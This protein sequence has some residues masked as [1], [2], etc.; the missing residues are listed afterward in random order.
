MSNKKNPSVADVMLGL[1]SIPIVH[2]KTF[3]KETLEIMNKFNLGIA[4]IVNNSGMLLGIVT[5]GDLRRKLLKVQKPFS[6]FFIDDILDHAIHNPVTT[7]PESSIE[8][9]V[10]VMGK[11]HVWDL[12]VVNDKGILVGLLHLHPAIKALLGKE[13]S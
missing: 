4:C 8:D 12:P 11:R 7:S 6:A 3:F 9:A 10:E 5:D 2:E 13:K 1:D